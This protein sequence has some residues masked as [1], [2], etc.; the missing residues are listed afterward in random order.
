MYQPASY[1]MLVVRYF[2][3][4]QRACYFESNKTQP[5]C[6]CM[7]D[8]R[9]PPCQAIIAPAQTPTHWSDQLYT[10]TLSRVLDQ[11]ARLPFACLPQVRGMLPNI[12]R[13]T[14]LTAP[15]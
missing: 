7:L 11:A 13:V 3:P 5:A 1:D 9:K 8:T 4:A 14:P 6:R 15:D 10:Y 2:K 12:T